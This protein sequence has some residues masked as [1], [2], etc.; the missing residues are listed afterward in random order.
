[1]LKRFALVSATLLPLVMGLGT[2]FAQAPFQPSGRS[3]A[4]NSLTGLQRQGP[5]VAEP[6]D[7]PN[8]PTMPLSNKGYDCLRI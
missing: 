3:A 7:Q 2:A 1:M 8:K 6:C 5:E 4:L